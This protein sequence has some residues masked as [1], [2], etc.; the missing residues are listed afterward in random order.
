MFPIVPEEK[1]QRQPVNVKFCVK[2]VHHIDDAGSRSDQRSQ[3][4]YPNQEKHWNGYPRKQHWLRETVEMVW[5]K[6]CSYKSNNYSL[7]LKQGMN[8]SISDFAQLLTLLGNSFSIMRLSDLYSGQIHSNRKSE[9]GRAPATWL[10]RIDGR[11]ILSLIV[12]IDR[13]YSYTKS[14]LETNRKLRE[15]W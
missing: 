13:C 15:Q 14:A 10:I 6:H 8:L 9:V 7:T 1:Q 12:S 2:L 4:E 5:L 3:V 11:Y